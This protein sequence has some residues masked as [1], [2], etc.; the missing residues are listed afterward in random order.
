MATTGLSWSSMDERASLRSTKEHRR[1]ITDVHASVMHTDEQSVLE[2]R[3]KG[4]ETC[5]MCYA[6]ALLVLLVPNPR[7]CP[8]WNGVVLI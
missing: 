6:F 7:Q 8:K 3:R 5:K 2:T 4:S 1:T